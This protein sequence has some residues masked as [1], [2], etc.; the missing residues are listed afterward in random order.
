MI[1]VYIYMKSGDHLVGYKANKIKQTNTARQ[2]GGITLP[3]LT[4]CLKTIANHIGRSPLK[5][6]K[7]VFATLLWHSFMVDHQFNLVLVN[8]YAGS[9]DV[10][11]C[12]KGSVSHLS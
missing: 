7:L 11:T 9:A 4:I 12:F 8:L 5:I 1:T 6:N 2:L 3:V 10:R